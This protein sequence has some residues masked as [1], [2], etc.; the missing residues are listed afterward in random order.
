M[1]LKPRLLILAAMVLLLIMLAMLPVPDTKE[2]EVGFVVL[3][4]RYG[5]ELRKSS[6]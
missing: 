6:V 5:L 4:S 3:T 2:S 1:E